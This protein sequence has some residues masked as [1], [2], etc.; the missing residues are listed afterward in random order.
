MPQAGLD[1][2]T[3]DFQVLFST[4][5]LPQHDTGIF[6]YWIFCFSR[7]SVESTE[8]RSISIKGKLSCPRVPLISTT[9][10]SAV[11]QRR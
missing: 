6:C 1:I 10:T 3:S 5:E 8:Y 2:R 9:T 11:D 7:D 4:T